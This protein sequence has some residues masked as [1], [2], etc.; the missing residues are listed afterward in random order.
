MDGSSDAVR[1]VVE[2]RGVLLLGARLSALLPRRDRPA[3]ILSNAVDVHDLLR[4]PADC[5]LLGVCEFYE[6]A[7]VVYDE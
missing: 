7:C 1:G 2:Q 6:T 3:R 5:Q 4:P